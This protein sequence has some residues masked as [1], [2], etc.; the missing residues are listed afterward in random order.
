MTKL[1]NR[2]DFLQTTAAIG[3]VGYFMGTSLDLRGQERSANEQLNVACFGVGG[4]GGSDSSNAS[5][6][7][8]VLAICDVDRNTLEGKGK[9]KG[10]EKAEKFTDYRELLEKF[11]KKIDIA[12]V[13]TP[14]HMHGPITLACMRLGISCYTQKPLTR[15]IY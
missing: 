5:Q 10:F 3:A 8:N 11:G 6:F 12:T 14:D 15:T 1:S 13:S 4:K 7:G 2:R 9:S